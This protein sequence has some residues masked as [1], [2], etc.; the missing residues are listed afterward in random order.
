MDLREM[1]ADTRIMGDDPRF[2]TTRW[3]LVEAA[4]NLQA[5]ES[6]VQSYWKPLYFFIR[7]Q[8]YD[9][10]TAKDLTQ[11]FFSLVI[12]RD[13][14]SRAD[15][16]RGRLR[17]FL[18][19]ALTNFMKDWNKAAARQK[20]GGGRGLVSLDFARGDQEYSIQVE[21]GDAPQTV[22]NR[23]W[24][25]ALWERA[26]GELDGDAAHLEAFRL[27]LENLD[28]AA[29]SA[30]TG[31]SESAAKSA[32]HRLKGQLRERVTAHIRD[33]CADESELA[34]ELAEFMAL[35]S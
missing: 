28:Y 1:D 12:E 32:V 31:L 21:R 7:Q 3:N 11:D 26:L 14:L 34:G 2:K 15:R 20:R 29:I 24:A 16:R 30:R 4:R 33:T 9:N 6:L 25:R 35:L 13:L 27:H 18:L 8:G 19:A 22:L 5:L 17:T 23:A 10:E